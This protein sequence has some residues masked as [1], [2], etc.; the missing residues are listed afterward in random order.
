MSTKRTIMA[1]PPWTGGAKPRT[2]TPFHLFTDAEDDFIPDQVGRVYL[3]IRDVYFEAKPGEITLGIPADV[4]NLI[5]QAGPV[6][7]EESQGDKYPTFP[8]K[9][10]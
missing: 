2:D 5:V 1:D 7:I 9:Q 4:W 3:R 10:G 8:K 6:V